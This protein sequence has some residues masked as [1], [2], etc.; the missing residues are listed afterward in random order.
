MRKAT[1]IGFIAVFCAA[2]FL[3]FR[4]LLPALQLTF[5]PQKHP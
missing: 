3:L 4:F 1:K 5:H 2:A